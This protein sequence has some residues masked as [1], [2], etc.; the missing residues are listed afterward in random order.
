[1]RIDSPFEQWPDAWIELPDEWLGLHAQRYAEA[2]EKSDGKLS[3]APAD[4]AAFLGLLDNWSLPGLT[5]PPDKWDYLALPLPLIAWVNSTV[6]PAF[7]GN[8]L[9]PK[10]SSAPS[11]QTTKKKGHT[12]SEE[13]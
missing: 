10:N 3:G 7:M 8:F 4:F 6:R 2:R 13:T 5:G 1:M 9:I 11:L 12:E